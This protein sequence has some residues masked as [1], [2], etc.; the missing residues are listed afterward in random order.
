MISSLSLFSQDKIVPFSKVPTK[1]QTYIA[2]HFPSNK[3]LQSQFDYNGLSK[4]YEIILSNNI[5]LKFDRKD[6]IKE[7][8]SIQELPESVV[9]TKI[10]EYLQSNYPTNFV[11][12]WELDNKK[13]SV[14][15]DNDIELEFTI[16][17]EFIRIDN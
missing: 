12:K 5:I 1:I 17:G 3:V 10:Y 4:E 16:N 2:T 13:Q 7:I 8:E 9:P 11:K 15:L 14:K 6:S